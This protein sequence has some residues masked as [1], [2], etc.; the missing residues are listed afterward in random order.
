MEIKALI[1]IVPLWPSLTLR[2]PLMLS[3]SR[4]NCSR[5]TPPRYFRQQ[6]GDRRTVD[7]V[8]ILTVLGTSI[9]ITKNVSDSITNLIS[10]KQNADRSLEQLRREVVD[11]QDVLQRPSDSLAGPKM[12]ATAFETQ[13]G[14]IGAHW[15]VGRRTMATCSER[16]QE[17]EELLSRLTGASTTPNSVGG[18]FV[19]GIRLNFTDSDIQFYKSEMRTYKENID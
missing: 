7:P 12:H 9:A 18:R 19:R 17:L 1:Q 6:H 14:N 5:S 15:R 2:S 13:T 10:Q 3:H 4:R 11:F 16:L 8:S